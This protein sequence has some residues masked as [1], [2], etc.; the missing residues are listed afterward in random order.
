ME[1]VLDPNNSLND[2]QKFECIKE[3]ASLKSELLEDAEINERMM[4]IA[5]SSK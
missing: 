5:K 4:D 3:L 2:N 1:Y